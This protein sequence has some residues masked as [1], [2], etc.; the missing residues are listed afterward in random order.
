[1]AAVAAAPAQ[2]ILL[3]RHAERADAGGEA[4]TDPGLS[5]AGRARAVALAELLRAAK[6]SAIYV[7]EYRR[8]QETAQ[9]LAEKL[10]LQPIV[11]PAKEIAQ[12][13]SKLR[14]ATGHVLVVGHSNTLPE[15]VRALGITTPLTLGE[16][17]YDDLFIVR[18]GP[19]P[20]LLRLHYR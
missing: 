5:A 12:L 10:A 20:D 6:I 7:T 4:Q 2:T 17:D 1:M 19:E 9:P 14:E 3:V 16:K 13:V 18:G 8:T 15:I 11:L